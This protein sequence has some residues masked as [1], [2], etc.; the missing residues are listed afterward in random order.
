MLNA[1]HKKQRLMYIFHLVND[2]IH[3]LCEFALFPMDGCCCSIRA[4]ASKIDNNT[5]DN[6][7]KVSL[8]VL[9]LRTQ[10][11]LEETTD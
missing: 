8:A 10:F 2:S 5:I 11:S 1:Y 6:P 4:K 9:F 3:I 7:I